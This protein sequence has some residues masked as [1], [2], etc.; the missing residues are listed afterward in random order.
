MLIQPPTIGL[1]DALW[2]WWTMFGLRLLACS[3]LVTAGA[4]ALVIDRQSPWRPLS[5]IVFFVCLPLACASGAVESVLRLQTVSALAWTLGLYLGGTAG[6]AVARPVGVSGVVDIYAMMFAA[7]DAVVALALG[8]GPLGGLQRPLGLPAQ[9]AAWAMAA[10]SAVG[11]IFDLILIL[12]GGAS[13]CQRDSRG[14]WRTGGALA[15]CALCTISGTVVA[16]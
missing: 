16:A 5:A 13:R 2:L 8:T 10:T 4:V 1:P 3:A 14:V 6:L 12:R 11:A 15:I 9:E 7:G